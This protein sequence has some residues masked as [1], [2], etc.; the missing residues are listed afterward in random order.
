M[1]VG[2]M[3]VLAVAIAAV[4]T[5]NV[6]WDEGQDDDLDAVIIAMLKDDLDP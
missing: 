3:L 2:G 4:T 6:R 1:L 5:T